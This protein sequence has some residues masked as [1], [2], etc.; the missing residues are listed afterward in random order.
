M[1]F[2]NYS[3]QS[4]Y[5]FVLPPLP[6]PKDS[7]KPYMSEETLDFHYGKHHATYV[8]NLNK[9]LADHEFKS[10][11]LEKIIAYSYNKPEFAGIFNNAAQI[12]NHSFFWNCISNTG[13]QPEGKIAAAIEKEFGSITSFKSAFKEAALTQFGSG[14]AWLV[15][16]KGQLKIIK[17]SN[18]HTP[19]AESM[20][21]LLTI[22]VWEHAYYLDYQNKRAEFVDN[23]LDYLIHW[24]QVDK[25]F[26]S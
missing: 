5:P 8:A 12:W 17:T 25:Y 7:L 20:K 2:C 22:D 1:S 15:L 21:P 9:L 23:F 26:Q 4:Q 14:W 6:F 10:Y 18:A 16:D 13:Q 11:D 24:K 3:N 19:I